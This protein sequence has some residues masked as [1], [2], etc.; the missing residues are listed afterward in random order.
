MTFG[1]IPNIA[2]D[3]MLN[4]VN[5]IAAKLK[6]HGY[7]FILSSSLNGFHDQ[8]TDI[9]K[10]APLM[11]HD[12]LSEK[13]DMV[14]SIGGDG[15]MLNTAYEVRKYKTPLLGVNMGKLGFLAEFKI[16]EIDEFITDI[17]NGNY[18]IEERMALEAICCE[19][20]E[21]ELFAI[22][23]LVIDKGRW[24]KMIELTIKIDDDYVSTFSADGIIASTP[25]GSTGYSL[26]V[27]GPIV[28]PKADAITLS[29]IAPHTLTV[30]PLVL[31]SN[32]KIEISVKSPA[33]NIQINCDGQ[34]VLYYDS[35]MTLLIFKSSNPIRLVHTDKT[36]YF[37]TLRTKLFWG[38]DARKANHQ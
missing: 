33:S 22:N 1:I 36:N 24:P 8:F 35:P 5:M 9:L 11:P 12:E 32:Q 20:G 28:S 27:G 15:T 19:T 21:K 14:I 10:Q 18:V 13:S 26:S 25:T 7:D 31:A 29:P 4:V 34:R 38:I 30:R 17:K 16:N 2:K 3:G 6:L 37:E 23:D